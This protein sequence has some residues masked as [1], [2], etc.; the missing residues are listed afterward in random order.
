[1]CGLIAY[2]GDTQTKKANEEARA[3]VIDQYE[4]QH[5]RGQRGFG[6]VSIEGGKVVIRRACEPVKFF[7]DIRDA[8]GSFF[9]VHHRLPTSTD[10]L[11]GQT[12][13][14]VVPMKDGKRK[15]LVMHNG[16]IGNAQTL[17]TKHTEELGYAYS[18]Y[19]PNESSATYHYRDFNDSEALAIELARFIDGEESQIGTIGS[20]AFLALEV[21]KDDEPLVFHFGRNEGHEL[22]VDERKGSGLLIASEAQGGEIAP[23]ELNSRIYTDGA[24]GAMSRRAMPFVVPP[25]PVVSRTVGFHTSPLMSSYSRPASAPTS[26]AKSFQRDVDGLWPTPTKRELRKEEVLEYRTSAFSA[27]PNGQAMLCYQEMAEEEIEIVEERISDAL[28]CLFN[29]FRDGELVKHSIT[30]SMAEIAKSLMGLVT[31][32]DD[33]EA[34]AVTADIDA[35]YQSTLASDDSYSGEPSNPR[36]IYSLS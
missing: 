20:V 27:D 19:L 23:F 15:L 11:L 17:F 21:S 33:L 36:T 12:H 18:T 30:K 1:M 22:I 2:M 28:V 10:N 16:V 5:A 6:V 32:Q 35:E 31:V 34:R 29:E 24:F 13:P 25:P 9:M 14:I 8:K 7:F 26:Y 4:E 3:K